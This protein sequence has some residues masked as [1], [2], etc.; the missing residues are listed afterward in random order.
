MTISINPTV[1]IDITAGKMSEEQFLAFCADN[2]EL[3]IEQDQDQNVIVIPPVCGE[4]GYFEN[5]TSVEL[6]AMRK[7]TAV[8]PSAQIQVSNFP[9]AQLASPML[10]GSA[11]NVGQHSHPKTKRNFYLSYPILLLKFARKL[12]A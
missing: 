11:M 3:R 12:T 7:A 2:C 4:S 1:E 8:F 6:N 10:V 9:M 5:K